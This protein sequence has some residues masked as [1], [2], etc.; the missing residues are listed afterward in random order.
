MSGITFDAERLREIGE[1][2]GIARLEVFGSVGRGDERDES[3]IDLLYELKP[4][5]RLGFAFFELE[6]ELSD[7][8]GRAVDLVARDAINEHIR[9]QILHDARSLY[10]A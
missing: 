7:L 4:G 1:R 10:A 3:D 6:D 8:F 2:Y 9:S 5:T